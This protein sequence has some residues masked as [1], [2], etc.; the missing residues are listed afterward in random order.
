MTN[1][2]QPS[3]AEKSLWRISRTAGVF[4][5]LVS[6]FVI[7]GWIFDIQFL[8]S[9]YPTFVSMKAN[10]AVAFL[11]AGIAL[12]L[13][14]GEQNNE[15]EKLAATLFSLLVI[16]IGGLTFCE[17]VF[18]IDFKIDQ[19]L[20]KEAAGTI[21]TSQPGRMAPNTALTFL[22]IG[23]SL[24]LLNAKSI[25]A[26]YL[27]LFFNATALL[28]SWAAFL[29][30]FYEIE[31]G[32]GIASYTKMALHTSLTFIVLSVG[33]IFLK[34]NQGLIAVLMG[35]EKSS[36]SMRRL[37]L[38][39]IF[40]PAL[41]GWFRWRGESEGIYS[42]SLGMIIMVIGTTLIMSITILWIASNLNRFEI[43]RAKTEVQLKKLSL[44]VEQSPDYVVITDRQGNIE[45][46]NAKFTE[47]T[48]Y[49]RDEVIGKNPRILK[50]GDSA[51]Q[52]YKELWD[53]ITSGKE[54]NGELCN[55]KKNGEYYWERISIS[56]I[57]NTKGDITHF[58]AVNEDITEHKKIEQIHLQFR[59][60]FES[61]PGMYLILKPDLTIVGASNA[62]LE[63][64]M[65]KREEIMGR[66]LFDVFPDNPNNPSA[67]GVSNLRSSLER[68]LKNGSADTMPIQKYDVR[69]PES[70][71]G[72][73]E[74]KYW[75]PV[76]SPVFGAD[77][78][79]E[80]I[81]HRVEDVTEFV[82]Q[83]KRGVNPSAETTNL[84][85]RMEKM[86]AEIFLR[87]QELKKLNLELEQRV[88]KRTDELRKSLERFRSTLDNMLEGCQIIDFDWKYVYLNDSAAKQGRMD[89]EKFIGRSMVELYP[90]I[91][92]TE[93][94]TALRR[95]MN[96]RKSIFLENE[97]IYPD[98]FQSWFEL[99]MQPVP[100]GVFI[101]SFD[102][103]ERKRAEEEIKKLNENLE[104]R[105]EERTEQLQMLNSE[106]EAFSYSV[107]H[108]LRAPLRHING[109]INLLNKDENANLNE[110]SS[111]Y[112]KIISSSSKEMGLL[113]DDLLH[114]SKVGRAELS[115]SDVHLHDLILKVKEEVDSNRVKKIKWGIQELP[116]VKADPNLMKIVLTNLLG[117]AVKYSSKADAPT[118]E[119]GSNTTSNNETI[120]YVK[121]NG[122]GFDMKYANKLFGVFQ[123]LHGSD[124]YEGTG[125]GLATVRR[126][127]HKHGGRTWAEGEVGKGATFYFSLPEKAMNSN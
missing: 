42:T 58:V 17:F 55:K 103:T 36:I 90:G 106:L 7:L 1:L 63:A 30:Y 121:D 10:T 85:E 64:T 109:F 38:A 124:E 27:S 87:G 54:W 59:A 125:I 72:A 12:F 57:V 41:F 39:A 110:K 67:D 94:F 50:S 77:G 71:L 98:G 4:V 62:Y 93:M 34:S 20:F 60:L 32:Y 83:K 21:G 43:E 35:K 33:V 6:C 45:Y 96:E 52:L 49:T 108:D 2:P 16:L 3:S 122:V 113:I 102:I 81:I 70:E 118:I 79:I 51:S 19:L 14:S 126:I 89:K 37:F 47:V 48:G 78:N 88:E 80:Y 31:E 105:V 5:I 99:S 13:F 11:L 8:K 112:L 75:S 97:F 111:R 66:G 61:V 95:C 82:L 116:I 73:F 100:E 26:F 117:N 15:S 68:V 28:I 18:G 84:Q 69:N 91:G 44:A 76:N 119:V 74:E 65:T 86:E 115:L 127:I 24:F 56:P 22:V 101:L 53:T 23:L 120:I 114:F 92:K 107:S 40:L 29:G 46:V 25:R 104:R 123:R 9:V